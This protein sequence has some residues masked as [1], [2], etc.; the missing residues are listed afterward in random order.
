MSRG[1]AHDAPFVG[2]RWWVAAAWLAGALIAQ[3][4]V[5]HYVQLRGAEPSLVLVAV[6]WYAIR[7]DIRRAA[8][9]GLIAG[10]FLDIIAAQT[11]AAWTVSTTVVA[12]IA[13]MLSRGFF[14]DSVPL[15]S[16]LTGIATLLDM[17]IFWIVRAFEG[18]PPGLG[19][20]HLH[21]AMYQALLNVVL[22]AVVMLIVRRYDTHFA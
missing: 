8:V 5:M 17:L 9:Y 22:M 4:T 6:V 1:K 16:V 10:L 15:V 7:V 13:G 14:A 18:Y 21:E 2:P 20:M 19:W 3:P 11:G 12:V